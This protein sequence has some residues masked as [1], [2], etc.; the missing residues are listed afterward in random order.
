MD[1]INVGRRLQCPEIQPGCGT[2]VRADRKRLFSGHEAVAYDVIW[3][4]GACTRGLSAAE[5]H[6]REWRGLPEVR[7]AE[8]CNELWYQFLM[9]QARTKALA[10]NGREP[11]Q[12]RLDLGKSA[13]TPGTPQRP[14]HAARPL[15]A[16]AGPEKPAGRNTPAQVTHAA[17]ALLTSRGFENVIVRTCQRV[18]GNVLQVAWVDGPAPLPCSRPW[19]P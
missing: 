13:D 10:L 7:S 2:I 9:A 1:V 19:R 18:A 12:N 14:L 17:R 11:A 16:A 6:R 5:L 15:P 8:H 3:D 4:N